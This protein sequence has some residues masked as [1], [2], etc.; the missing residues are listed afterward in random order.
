MASRHVPPGHPRRRAPRRAPPTARPALLRPPTW[1]VGGPSHGRRRD[2][3]RAPWLTSDLALLFPS[4]RHGTDL[5]D[6][7]RAAYVARQPH[8]RGASARH[9]TGVTLAP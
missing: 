6:L 2:R 3:R 9:G 4:G 8:R 7:R 5:Q 1:S